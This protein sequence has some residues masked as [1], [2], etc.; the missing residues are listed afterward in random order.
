[1]SGQTHAKG[2]SGRSLRGPELPLAERR[3][4]RRE[5]W[6]S[7]VVIAAIVAGVLLEQRI[8]AG[9]QALPF[10]T[11]VPFLFLNALNV[12]LIVLL[13][14]LIAR[15]LVKLVFERR[16]GILGSHL[17]LKFVAAFT[18]V[19]TV[20]TAVLFLVSSSLVDD[21][22][23]LPRPMEMFFVMGGFFARFLHRDVRQ[24]D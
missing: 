18:L 8:E 21:L 23:R 14:Y 5:L 7:G 3:R 1:M 19:A 17:N 6:I 13:V 16:R 10:G 9:T 22:I 20:P 2:S 4:R 24:V 12:I 11:G 15:N